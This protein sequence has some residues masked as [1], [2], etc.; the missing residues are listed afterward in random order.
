MMNDEEVTVPLYIYHDVELECGDCGYHT[1]FVVGPEVKMP[2]RHPKSM[3]APMNDNTEETT[4]RVPVRELL[5]YCAPQR[6]LSQLTHRNS[7]IKVSGEDACR[8]CGEEFGK[9]TFFESPTPGVVHCWGPRHLELEYEDVIDPSKSINIPCPKCRSKNW[10]RLKLQTQH[11]T[12]VKDN[13]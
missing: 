10:R 13:R 1:A 2:V 12:D 8:S 6:E 5:T 9:L 11:Y 4:V 3:Y 7:N